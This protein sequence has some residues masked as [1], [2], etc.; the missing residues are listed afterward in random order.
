MLTL[1]SQVDGF[2]VPPGGTS[3]LPGLISMSGSFAPTGE[4]RCSSLSLEG[5][6]LLGHSPGALQAWC[7]SSFPS[8]DLPVH[9]R[10]APPP[11]WAANSRAGPAGRRSFALHQQLHFAFLFHNS[12]YTLTE[13]LAEN[14]IWQ[15]KMLVPILISFLIKLLINVG[16]ERLNFSY[17]Q[18]DYISTHS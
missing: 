9:L 17:M 13:I 3:I 16:R 6:I 10:H 11:H 1:S 14:T 7:T 15:W 5:F 18:I 8:G 4:A 2:A 12:E